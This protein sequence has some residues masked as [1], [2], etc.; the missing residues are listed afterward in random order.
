MT[1][2]NPTLRTSVSIF[3]ARK[4]ETALKN[5]IKAHATTHTI[6]S[7]ALNTDYTASP[8]VSECKRAA[9][10]NSAYVAFEDRYAVKSRVYLWKR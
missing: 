9:D 5:K 7:V 6:S 10:S 2:E 1:W 3:F 4:T 8:K